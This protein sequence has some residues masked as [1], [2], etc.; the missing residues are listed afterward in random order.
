MG[1]I[2]HADRST[3]IYTLR[4]CYCA[5][6]RD[7]SVFPQSPLPQ[8]CIENCKFCTLFFFDTCRAVYLGTLRI[9]RLAHTVVSD[10]SR[11]WFSCARLNAGLH[12]LKANRRGIGP[13]LQAD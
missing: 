4:A 3:V 10:F 13:G 2:G 11:A 12:F 6:W 9:N 7:V 1:C 8:P 5:V